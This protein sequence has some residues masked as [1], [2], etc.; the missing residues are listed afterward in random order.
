L[1]SI[2]ARFGAQHLAVPADTITGR[3]FC[4]GPATALPT[5]FNCASCTAAIIWIRIAVVACL[6]AKLLPVATDCGTGLSFRW[7]RKTRFQLAIGGAPIAIGNITII[8]CLGAKLLPV[9]IDRM[10]GRSSRATATCALPT[11]LHATGCGAPV[12]V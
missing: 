12:S 11:R 6:V 8:A 2:I 3:R 7:A 4:C 1:V 5:S 9:P 10:A